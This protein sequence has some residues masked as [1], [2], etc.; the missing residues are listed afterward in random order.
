ML[1]LEGPW[2]CLSDV[3]YG[4]TRP[5]VATHVTAGMQVMGCRASCSGRPAS[6][7]SSCARSARWAG[8]DGQGEG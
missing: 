5:C 8:R 6:A 1:L 3:W 2:K 7:A 4:G